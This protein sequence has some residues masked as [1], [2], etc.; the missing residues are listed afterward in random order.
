MTRMS[1]GS[2]ATESP[3]EFSRREYGSTPVTSPARQSITLCRPAPRSTKI[4]DVPRQQDEEAVHRSAHPR[5]SIPRRRDA[6]GRRVR[7]ATRA[8]PGAPRRGS[9][10]LR[11]DRRDSVAVTCGLPGGL[12]WDGENIYS[13]DVQLSVRALR[14]SGAMIHG[15]SPETM[16]L[17]R[18]SPVS[19]EVQFLG[20]RGTGERTTANRCTPGTRR[21][22]RRW[23]RSGGA[24]DLH[25]RH[26]HGDQWVTV[27]IEVAARKHPLTAIRATRS[28]SARSS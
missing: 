20:G 5:P 19:T 23:T 2:C 16:E 17:G 3:G 11:A 14:N 10:V 13:A 27:E 28:S 15:Q 6:G 7:P 18:T 1:V 21:R 8:P 4:V 12:V 9:C 25:V 24:A 26:D 22:H